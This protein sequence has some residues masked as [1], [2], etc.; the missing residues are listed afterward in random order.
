MI[1]PTEA[2]AL[3]EARREA[4]ERELR[5]Q[6]QLAVLPQQ[7]SKL[8]QVTGNGL[9]WAGAR[10]VNWGEGM[11]AAKRTQRFEVVG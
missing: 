7:P 8:R 3:A 4:F 6:Q 5:V 2:L 1:L 10:L 9:I 11:A